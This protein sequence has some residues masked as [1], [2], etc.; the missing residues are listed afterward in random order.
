MPII[1]ERYTKLL[2]VDYDRH[3]QYWFR[4]DKKRK[5]TFAQAKNKIGQYAS[6]TNDIH[7]YLI[8]AKSLVLKDI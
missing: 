6:N 4:N 3:F 2:S 1:A 7:G 8:L 5:Q